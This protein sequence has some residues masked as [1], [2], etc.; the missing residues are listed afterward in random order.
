MRFVAGFSG[1]VGAQANKKHHESAEHRA[2]QYNDTFMQ[3]PQ[4]FRPIRALVQDCAFFELEQRQYS[5]LL[6]LI[7]FPCWRLLLFALFGYGLVIFPCFTFDAD[8]KAQEQRYSHGN[9]NE[10][11]SQP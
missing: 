3:L 5:F 4:P 8:P 7:A 6:E 2:A 1:K 10:L 11:V 9:W